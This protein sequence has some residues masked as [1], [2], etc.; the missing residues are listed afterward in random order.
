MNT[1]WNLDYWSPKMPLGQLLGRAEDCFLDGL[2]GAQKQ[3]NN[4]K[5]LVLHSSPS[6]L[7]QNSAFAS[8]KCIQIPLH[9]HSNKTGVPYFLPYPPAYF[10]AVIY[11]GILDNT[12]DISR[13][14]F[15][16]K[17]V[18]KDDGTLRFDATNRNI[19]TWIH[20]TINQ[21]LMGLFPSRFQNWRLFITPEEI[22]RVLS[23]YKFKNL[24]TRSYT[25][26]FD[27]IALLSGE[28][29]L[30]SISVANTD[31][32]SHQYCMIAT[33]SGAKN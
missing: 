22:T 16:A 26:S 28:G 9:T 27:L 3:S 15:E 13:V 30:P 25:S 21:R 31:T 1:W 10:D 17:R 4:L 19:G 33:N 32:P 6:K 12:L 20:H 23:A 7:C 29:V 11:Q 14:I 2:S 24:K 5:Y 18:L 8:S